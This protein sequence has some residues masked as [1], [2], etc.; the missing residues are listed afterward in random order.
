MSSINSN[1][2]PGPLGKVLASF[3]QG[4]SPTSSEENPSE[5]SSAPVK[6]EKPKRAIGDLELLFAAFTFSPSLSTLEP[7]LRGDNHPSSVLGSER[8]LKKSC[9]VVASCHSRS[10]ISIL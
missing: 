8:R 2:Y 10:S 1:P 9:T 7:C 3:V 6:K 5:V 4:T